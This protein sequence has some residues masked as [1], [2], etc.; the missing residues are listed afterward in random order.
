MNGIPKR[1]FGH[2]TWWQIEYDMFSKFIPNGRVINKVNSFVRE[3]NICNISS[4]HIRMTDLQTIMPAR[5]KIS[6]SGF[7]TFVEEAPHPVFLMTGCVGCTLALDLVSSLHSCLIY[8][9][10]SLMYS[11]DPHTQILFIEKYG[12]KIVVYDKVGTSE[13]LNRTSET[14]S[15]VRYTT[16]EVCLFCRNHSTLNFASIPLFSF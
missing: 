10:S 6:L 14:L 8:L 7:F 5:K 2:P 11:D 13:D 16:L 1:R 15:P 4:M 3:N 12:R 9:P